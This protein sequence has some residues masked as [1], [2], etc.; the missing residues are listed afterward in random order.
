M[1][2]FKYLL[3]VLLIIG[4]NIFFSSCEKVINI[5]LNSKNTQIVI[6]G[7]ITNLQ[8]PYTIIL[9]QTVNFND[10]NTFP[11]VSNATVTIN[12][13]FGNSDILAETSAG[14]YSTSTIQG[15]CNR[16]YTLKVFSNGKEYIATSYMNAP[17]TIDTLTIVTETTHNGSKKTISVGF[18]DPEGISNYY[19]FIKTINNIP[20]PTIYIEDDLLQDG[21]TINQA[22][23]SKYQDETTIKNGDSVVIS[24]QVIDKNVYNYL[25]T[26]NQLSGASGLINQSTSPANPISNFNNGALGYFNAYSV[27]FKELKINK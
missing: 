4:L 6:E 23:L 24:L 27:T 12:D 3:F 5:D 17:V 25:R 16:N 21:N 22:L 20:Q 13:D 19:R 15:V 18:T 8:G 10:A 1:K 14:V 26:L 11:P 9:T 7:N 2:K